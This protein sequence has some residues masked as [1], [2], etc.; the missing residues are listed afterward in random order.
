[1]QPGSGDREFRVAWEKVVEH[2]RNHAPEFIVFQCGADSI[3][4]DPLA[5]LQYTPAAHAHAARSL[6]G[7][8]N[9]LCNGRLMGFG[10]GGYNRGNI[11]AAWC[12][13]LDELVKGDER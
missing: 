4:G 7:L 6:C 1:M 12:A 13:V 5:H 11:A 9:E 2:V 10:G 3:A 8:A